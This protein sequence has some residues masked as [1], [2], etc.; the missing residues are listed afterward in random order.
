VTGRAAE[1]VVLFTGSGCTSAINKLVKILGL[2]LPA[3]TKMDQVMDENMRPVV[4]VGPMEH[5]SNLLPWRERFICPIFAFAFV[6]H[7]LLIHYS[8]LAHP[9]S[10]TDTLNEFR[11]AASNN[12]YC[13]NI[14]FIYVSKYCIGDSNSIGAKWY[15]GLSPSRR[16]AYQS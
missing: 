1:D 15:T 9:F 14:C 6:W 5:H 8:L 3:P 16:R 11:L 13:I 12:F 4:F 7:V 2:H 10:Y